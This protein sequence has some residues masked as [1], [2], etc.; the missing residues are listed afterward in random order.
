MSPGCDGESIKSMLTMDLSEWIAHVN[1]IES[2]ELFDNIKSVLTDI[3]AL[4]LEKGFHPSNVLTAFSCLNIATDIK[5]HQHQSATKIQAAY[6]GNRARGARANLFGQ[7]ST[8][9]KSATGNGSADK[10]SAG[11]GPA[12]GKGATGDS[13]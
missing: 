6:R 7:T 5:K 13:S 10:G 4:Q 9:E 12:A 8:D 11:K 1:N 3:A 2:G